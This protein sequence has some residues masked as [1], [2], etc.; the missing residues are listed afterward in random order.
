MSRKNRKNRARMPTENTGAASIAR[1]SIKNTGYSTGAASYSKPGLI[2]W[3]PIRSSPQSDIDANSNALRGR[4]ADQVMNNPIAASAINT[5]RTNVIGAGLRLSP[6]P[7]FDILGISADEAKVWSRKTKLEFHIWAGSKLCD[8]MRK[9]NFYDLQ[10][11]AYQ[12]YMIDGDSFVLLQY[13]SPVP[14]MKYS[15]RL[16]GVEASRVCNPGTTS[17]AMAINP[18][19]VTV[20]NPDN[21][22]RIINGVEVDNDGAVVAYWI[23]SRYPY[24]PANMESIPTWSRVEAFGAK[25]GAPNILQICHDVRF[26]QY[27][28]VPELAPVLEVLKQISRYTDAELT[29]AIIKS[30]FSLFFMEKYA[31]DS[32]E[33]PLPEAFSQDEKVTL[34]P[35]AFEIGSGTMNVLPPGFDVKTIDGSRQLSTYEPFVKQL[36]QQLGAALEIPQEVVMKSFN[37]SYSASRAALLQA[38]AAFKMRRTWFTRDFT[39][40]AYEAWLTEAV[41]IGRI[42]APGFFTDDLI[43]AAWCNADWYGPVMGVLDPVKDAQGGALRVQ[44]GFSTRERETAEM[45]GM[46]WNENIEQ[47]ALDLKKMDELGIPVLTAVIGKQDKSQPEGGQP[48]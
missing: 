30:F 32:D 2:S 17:L 39:Q 46:D 6:K 29:S 7:R 1:K 41:A 37:S 13:R 43:R 4:S 12:S 3:T 26:E 42:E 9:N 35:N 20:R 33:F 14:G 31:S 18:L 47:N 16:R 8:I 38:W 15:L 44:Y 22:N 27:R 25:S 11:I 19:T 48:E 34:D 28:G 36:V 40:P 10:D 21:G 23:C 24:D 5:S 45:S